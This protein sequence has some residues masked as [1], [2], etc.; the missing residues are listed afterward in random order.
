M[1]ILKTLPAELSAAA[2]QLEAIVSSLSAQHAGAAAAT[3]AIAPAAADPVSLQQAAIFSA[4]GTQYQATA[5][6]AQTEQQQYVNTLNQTSGTYA[7]AE[8]TNSAQQ[9]L[10]PVS[11]INQA[12][13]FL[14]SSNGL[15][16][17]SSG[18]TS[19]AMDEMGNWAS[20]YSDTI[21]M[22][23][24]G[25]LSAISAPEEAGADLGGL[26]GL[27]GAADLAGTTTP[28][29]GSGI[30]GMGA[31]P[32]ASVGSAT[33]VGKLSVPPSWGGTVTTVSSTSLMDPMALPSAG[34]TTAAPQAGTG[35]FVPGMPGMGAAARNGAGF[36]APRYGVKPLVM[37][38][39]T[40][41]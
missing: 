38:K 35:T 30:A 7:A 14:S 19:I 33:M 9:S 34:W 26:G 2:A 12:Y 32:M 28:A 17:P 37:P 10:D 3:T 36:G 8:A 23:G 39:P 29:V 21:G 13:N 22:G 24:G 18:G 6:Q 25:L 5:T 4:Y 40:T 27:A 20:A 16:S 1:S 11:L 15:F 31:M 41:V